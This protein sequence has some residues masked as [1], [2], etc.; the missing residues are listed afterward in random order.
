MRSIILEPDAG[1]TFVGSSYSFA[2]ARDFARFGLL[3]LND[4]VWNGERILP[5]GWVKFSSTPT[6]GAKRGEYAAQWWT[7]AG[8]KNNESN[9][10]YPHV[11]TDCF[12]ADGFEGQ[13]IFIIPSKKLVIVRLGLTKKDNF[14][15][16]QF[17]SKVIDCLP[18]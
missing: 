10:L 12:I 2:T 8:E 15:A 3:Y 7:N 4:G 11:P 14:D 13:N 17:V 6:I 18:Q 9:R 5:E 1:G 16:D